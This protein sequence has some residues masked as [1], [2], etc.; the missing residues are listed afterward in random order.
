MTRARR[1][2]PRTLRARLTL[3]FAV[4]TG[5]AVAVTSVGI[6]V[7]LD[8]RVDQAIDAGLDGRAVTIAGALG[9]GAPEIGEDEPFAVVLDRTGTVLAA[10]STISDPSSVLRPDE[11]ARALNGTLIVN[12]SVPGL[13]SDAR[14]L[15]K[16]DDV[17]GQI[18]VV[19]TGIDLKSLHASTGRL[20]TVLAIGAAALAAIVAGGAWLLIGAAL[21]PVHRLSAEAEEISRV[22]V[23]RRLPDPGT[24]DE[25]GEL[26]RTLNAMLTRLAV[27]F[28]RERAFVD[29]ASHELRSP[30]AVL[31]TELELALSGPQ[32]PIVQRAALQSALEETRRLTRLAQDLLVLSRVSAD[33]LPARRAAV[34]VAAVASEVVDRL[35]VSRADV[36]ID[37]SGAARMMTDPD[38]LEQIFTN[39]LS[40]ALRYARS[41]VRVDVIDAETSVELV[42]ADDGPGFADD[43]LPRAFDRFSQAETSR[44]RSEAGGAGLG[45]AI[46]AALCATLGATVSVSNVGINGGASARVHLP[47]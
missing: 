40:N 16:A 28:D 8:R 23:A 44:T 13:S 3:L 32:D 15:A 17:N 5:I 35:A 7:V 19:V 37:V 46:V 41:E 38:R 4:G 18:F 25:I 42:V 30:L 2:I 34:D 20:V 24:A 39:L 36:A 12:R 6:S 33:Q 26:A 14:L 1:L 29:D 9:Q 21:R 31:Q 45:L 47:K 43:F 27:T 10:S 11:L 22:D